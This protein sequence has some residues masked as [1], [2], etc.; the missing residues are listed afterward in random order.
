M[1]RFLKPFLSI[2]LVLSIMFSTSVSAFAASKEV[3]LSDIR[4]IYADTYKEAQKILSETKLT[5][6]QLLDKNLNSGSGKTGV[7]LAYKTT[8]HVDDA[9]TDLA[10]Q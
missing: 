5:N 8:T 9:I 3:Y 1:K 7:W 6:Y 10:R 2:V 4:M